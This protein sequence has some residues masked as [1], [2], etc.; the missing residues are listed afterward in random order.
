MLER[1]GRADDGSLV[2]VRLTSDTA[3]DDIDERLRTVWPP[4]GLAAHVGPG[5]D[6]DAALVITGHVATDGALDLAVGGTPQATNAERDGWDRLESVLMLHA[7]ER[8]DGEVAVHAALIAWGD[9]LV[10][11]PGVSRAGK[12]TL[13]VALADRGATLAS[14][15]LALV[16]LADGL[17]RGWPRPARLR[18]GARHGVHPVGRLPVR[19][20][21]LVTFDPERPVSMRE[22]GQAEATV[23][24]LANTV[25]AAH[26]PD[27]ALTAALMITADAVRVSGVRGE[28]SD[29]ARGLLALLDRPLSGP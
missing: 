4:Y 2:A 27:D 17:V 26:R 25:C 11:L 23:G 3:P 12:T 22:I 20:V 6:T 29:T 7:A 21:A 28:A 5:E 19:L 15:E 14:D 16:S 24:V 10:L 9:G 18:G 13:A 8:L 1:W